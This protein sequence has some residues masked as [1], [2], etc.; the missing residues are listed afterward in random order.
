MHTFDNAYFPGEP[1]LATDTWC[2]LF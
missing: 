1:Q 2:K